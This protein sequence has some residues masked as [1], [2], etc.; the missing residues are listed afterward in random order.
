MANEKKNGS[1][2][3]CGYTEEAFLVHYAMRHGTVDGSTSHFHDNYELYYLLSGQ[4]Q[5]FIRDRVY[6][7]EKGDLVFIPK[8]DLHRTLDAGPFHERMLLYF[9]DSFLD[10]ETGEDEQLKNYVLQPFQRTVPVLRLPKDDRSEAEALFYKIIREMGNK[11]PGFQ[12][13]VKALVLEL[14]VLVSRCAEQETESV[15]DFETP[16]QRKVAE[17]STFIR[18]NYKNPLTL[19]ELSKQFYMSTYYLSRVFKE[20]SGFSFIE[21]LN[22]IRIKEAQSLLHDSDLPIVQI[23]ELVGFESVANF[24]RVF[25]QSVHLS[26]MQYRKM[27]RIRT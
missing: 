18:Q 21:Y 3:T 8:Y 26:P 25:K 24:G 11:R 1:N 17:I 22:Y 13:Y 9:K 5:Y 2:G 12:L 6:R 7:I 23:A 4:R 14:L 15:F 27:Q 20:I 16:L 10:H 19:S